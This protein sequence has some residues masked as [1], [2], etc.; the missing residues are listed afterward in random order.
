[1][2]SKTISGLSSKVALHA[3]YL[4]SLSLSS[5]RHRKAARPISATWSRTSSAWAASCTWRTRTWR[6]PT[7]I[8]SLSDEAFA[9]AV[10]QFHL[11]SV[12]SNRY[13]F[14]AWLY[15]L[16][17]NEQVFALKKLIFFLDKLLSFIWI[18]VN[19]KCTIWAILTFQQSTTS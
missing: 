7:W 19:E 18:Q 14:Q 16:N 6:V 15:N 3:R 8:F 17:L 5:V 10:N 1:M 9:V 12:C 11:C 4:P 13:F 2:Q